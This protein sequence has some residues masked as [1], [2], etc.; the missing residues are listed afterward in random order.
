MTALD[1]PLPGVASL[2]LSLIIKALLAGLMVLAVIAALDYLYQRQRF[3]ARHRMTR[4]ELRDEIKQAKAILR[5]RPGSGR[6]GSS[7]RASG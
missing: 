4:Q 2:A 1:L 3:T 6:S 5:S 7:G